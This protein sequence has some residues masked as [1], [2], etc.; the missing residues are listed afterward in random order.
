MADARAK[1][2]SV[3]LLAR[4]VLVR[5]RSL[6][7]LE[8][9]AAAAAAFTHCM[10]LTEERTPAHPSDYF[11]WRGAIVHNIASC[12][13]HLGRAD[14]AL[15]YYEL[16][17]RDFERALRLEAATPAWL[18]EGE[19]NRRR[20]AFVRQRLEDVHCGRTPRKDTYLDSNGY[21][22]SVEVSP[23]AREQAAALAAAAEDLCAGR[24]EPLATIPNALL[25]LPELREGEASFEGCAESRA[26]LHYFRD[27]DAIW[28]ARLEATAVERHTLDS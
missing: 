5:A 22:H 26:P 3:H 8:D 14:V 10:A 15:A 25:Q 24:P 7:T 4:H 27:G 19:V 12:H 23:S 11:E 28:F 9:Y 2:E 6:F 20:L 13:H 21:R 1:F 17:A 16:A 18:A